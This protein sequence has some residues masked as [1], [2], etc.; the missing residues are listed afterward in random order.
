MPE[1]EPLPYEGEAP[2]LERISE[3]P[4]EAYAFIWKLQMSLALAQEEI[5]STQK[6]LD[7]VVLTNIKYLDF[8][9][10]G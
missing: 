1:D 7:D 5:K 10:S 8:D 4:G 9:K 3:H 2:S 6:K